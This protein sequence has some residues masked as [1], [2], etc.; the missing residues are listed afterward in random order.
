MSEKK[1]SMWAACLLLIVCISIVYIFTVKAEVKEVSLTEEQVTGEHIHTLAR[2]MNHKP[3]VIEDFDVIYQ[4]PQLPTGCEVTA[5]TMVLNYY[6]YDADKTT[7]ARE[8][9]PKTGYRLSYKNGKAYGPDLDEVFVG[10]PF[11]DGTIC[12]PGAVVTAANA[13]LAD[14]EKD[15]V[16]T[17]GAKTS[18]KMQARDITGTTPA[19]L[20]LRV[21]N[22]QPVV[23]HV[24]IAMANREK[25]LGWYAEDGEYVDWSDN[26]HGSVLIGWDEET[27]T[28]ACPLAGIQTYSR[29]QF[30]KVYEERGCRASVLEKVLE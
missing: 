5:M 28:I 23:V 2:N 24:T 18:V 12:G 26:D 27:V 15:E 19:G 13:F 20:Y 25:T 17:S 7:M 1:K 9:L 8:Y 29:A 22:G 16:L 10:N 6:G 30:E 11:G 3:H 14:Y 21:S 4:L